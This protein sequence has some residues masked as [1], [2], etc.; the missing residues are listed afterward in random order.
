MR[1][2]QIAALPQQLLM[3][4]VRHAVQAPS[5]HNTQPWRFALSGETI[6]ILPDFSRRLPVVDPDDH[7]LFISL[8]AALENLTIAAKQRGLAPHTDYFPAHAADSLVVRLLPMSGPDE[9]ELFRAIPER[10]ST[11]STYDGTPIPTA[12][13]RQLEAA[14]VQDGVRFRV[15]T[16]RKQIESVTEFVKEGNRKQVSDPAFVRE[17]IDWVRFSRKEAEAHN[18]GLTGAVMGMPA[19][20]RW[21]GERIMKTILRPEA[22][23]SKAEERIRSSSALMLFIAEKHDRE[24]WV[25]LG[26]SFERVS[27]AATVLGIRNAH[28]NMP[29]EVPEVREQFRRYLGLAEEEPLLLLRIGYGK[30]MP[31]SPRRPPSAVVLTA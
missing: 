19:A 7:A 12:D 30:L 4:L 28:M 3:E 2:P 27:L 24:H 6:D 13:L 20:P 22:E 16:D 14:S 11:R 21:L 1:S 15:F 25:K 29:C 8:G 10:Q 5:G 23:A 18:D 31:R 26:R 17:L 9:S